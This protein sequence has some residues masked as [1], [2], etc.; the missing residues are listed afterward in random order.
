M[1]RIGTDVGVKRRNS[2]HGGN[3]QCKARLS[4]VTKLN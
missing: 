3:K 1:R 2:V 4:M